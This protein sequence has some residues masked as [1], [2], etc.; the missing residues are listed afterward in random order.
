MLV[1]APLNPLAGPT[2]VNVTCQKQGDTVYAEGYV[3]NWWSR[4]RDQNGFISN[5]FIN[6]PAQQLP[7]VPICYRS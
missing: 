6:H 1:L 5:I 4:L 7:G 3:N 2:L